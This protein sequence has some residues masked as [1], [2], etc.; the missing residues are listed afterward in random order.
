MHVQDG[1]LNLPTSLGTAA[2]AATGVAIALRVSRREL[3]DRTAPLAGLVA[4]FVFAA[5]PT[6][7][8]RDPGIS[9]VAPLPP[10][11]RA[12]HRHLVPGVVPRPPCLADVVPG[13]RRT[14]P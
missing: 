11:R 6:S 13:P 14:S 8:S 7:V 3:D 10:C 2:V 12:V 4:V 5:M 9:S 1:L